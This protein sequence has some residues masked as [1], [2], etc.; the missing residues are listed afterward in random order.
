MSIEF[1]SIALLSRS[2]DVSHTSADRDSERFRKFMRPKDI[3]KR[4]TSI[5]SQA[6]LNL[7]A[8][9]LKRVVLA[10]LQRV[11]QTAVRH[12]TELAGRVFETRGLWLNCN[13]S[14]RPLF[15]IPQNRIH[16]KCL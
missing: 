4:S 6:T 3:L 11:M 2:A 1:K 10:K 15:D 16:M 13:V 9:C 5:H 7:R 14:C 8:A 12:P